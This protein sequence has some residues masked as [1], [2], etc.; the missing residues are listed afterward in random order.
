M[1]KNRQLV[2][3]FVH[4]LAIALWIIANSIVLYSRPP[5]PFPYILLNL[6]LS[7]LAALQAPII[8]M[9]QNRQASKDR[10]DAKLDYDVN[11]RAEIQIAALHEKIDR[12]RE[13]ELARLCLAVDEQ[14]ALILALER[15][16]TER[17]A[18]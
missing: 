4:N 8:M 18:R 16:L 6:M 14:R 7:C 9:S 13:Q 1:I 12:T 5:D 3:E 10:S 11:V 2:S 17:D 15:R